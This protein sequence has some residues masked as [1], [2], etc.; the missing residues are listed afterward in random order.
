MRALFSIVPLVY[1]FFIPAVSM[2]LISREKGL[3]TIEILATL[4]IRDLDLVLGK[5]LAAFTLIFVGL[6]PSV[7]IV[8]VHQ[9]ISYQDLQHHEDRAEVGIYQY[10]IYQDRKS[11]V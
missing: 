11:V 7:A 9:Y 8:L 2:G 3:G 10:Q 4:P 5:Y 1:L 6:L